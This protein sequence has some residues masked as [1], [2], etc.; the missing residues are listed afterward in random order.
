VRRFFLER[1]GK[2][3]RVHFMDGTPTT[4]TFELGRDE[5]RV[6]HWVGLHNLDEGDRQWFDLSAYPVESHE[7]LAG[8]G[9]GW[10]TREEGWIHISGGE[11]GGEF[12]VNS[13]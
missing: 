5:P 1:S 9:A 3:G 8:G 12:S 13:H 11:A 6:L 10:G 4:V 7:S 2:V